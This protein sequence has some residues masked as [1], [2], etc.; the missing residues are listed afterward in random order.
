MNR[1]KRRPQPSSLGAYGDNVNVA[2]Q[3]PGI[4]GRAGAGEDGRIPGDVPVTAAERCFPLD[5]LPTASRLLEETF[6]NF[7]VTMRPPSFSRPPFV[8]RPIDIFGRK[9]LVGGG[10]AGTF[11]SI[12]CYRV[13]LGH[14]ANIVA[15]GHMAPSAAAWSDLAW[16]IT[17][18]G[19]PKVPW[20]D[21]R[22]QIWE[23]VPAT[24]LP[25]G[26]GLREGDQVCLQAASLSAAVYEVSGRLCGWNYDV[27]S[28]TG[29]EIRSTLVD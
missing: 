5:C 17:V 8:G 10:S 27:R 3:S 14:R 1:G 13:P 6:R 24:K 16:R 19:T 4:I 28:E 29:D 26:I 22:I 25:S 20:N 15:A 11:Q 2:G 18:N 12:V 7:S 21:I 9:V 23:L